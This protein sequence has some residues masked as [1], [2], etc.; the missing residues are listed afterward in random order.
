VGDKV[1]IKKLEPRKEYDGLW[2]DDEMR[3]FANNEE[4]HTVEIVEEYKCRKPIYFLDDVELFI[5]NDEMLE[6]VS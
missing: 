1:K 3:E 2:F 5:F 4:T 6:R